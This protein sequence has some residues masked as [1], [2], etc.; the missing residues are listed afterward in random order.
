MP[1]RTTSKTFGYEPDA[2]LAKWQMRDML[3]ALNGPSVSNRNKFGKGP[4]PPTDREKELRRLV[5][6]W[7]KSGPNLKK[8]LKGER[9]LVAQAQLVRTSVHFSSSARGHVECFLPLGESERLSPRQEASRD[10][11]MFVTNPLCESLGGPCPRCESYYLKRTKRQKVYCKRSCSSGRT[12]LSATRR[13]REREQA[14]KIRRAQDALEQLDGRKRIHWK[15]WVSIETGYHVRWIS[16]A[17]N[18]GLLHGNRT[19]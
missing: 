1:R 14:E 17:A 6:R 11:L 19:S 4:F 13:R 18:K 3:I 10:F 16:R 8:M 5:D 9:E 7:M 12:A 2:Q 15:K